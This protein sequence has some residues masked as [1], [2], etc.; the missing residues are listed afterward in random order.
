MCR[1][2]QGKKNFF[3]VGLQPTPKVRVW[4]RSTLLSLGRECTPLLCVL[5][6][7]TPV[8]PGLDSSGLSAHSFCWGLH[9]SAEISRKP[10]FPAP[11]VLTRIVS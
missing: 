5:W 2:N 11:A 8:R 3:G 10:N 7:L 4:A 9:I 6:F 1:H